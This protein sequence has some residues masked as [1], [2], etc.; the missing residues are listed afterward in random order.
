V[1][2]DLLAALTPTLPMPRRCW[3]ASA[4]DS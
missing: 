2:R 1:R 4:R 3:R